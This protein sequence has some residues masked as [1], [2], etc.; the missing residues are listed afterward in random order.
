[1]R[2]FTAFATC[3]LILGSLAVAACVA[4]GDSNDP[5]ATDD[6]IVGSAASADSSGVSM[7]HPDKGESSP[8]LVGKWEFI[9]S[10]SSSGDPPPQVDT[11]FDFIN[12]T[13]EKLIL[14]YAFFERDGTFCGCDRDDFEPDKTVS[15]TM[16]GESRTDATHSQDHTKFPKL[17][18]C[19]DKQG[20]MKAI[21]FK[22]KGKKLDLD[23]ATQVGFQIRAFADV[24]EIGTDPEFEAVKGSVM[25][26]SGLK[27]V[28]IKQS[29]L[30]EIREIHKQ[31]IKVV[32][33][34]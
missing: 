23:D 9:P 3:S 19:H 7:S 15:Y 14:E 18:N 8:Y 2:T 22:R 1:M 32:G 11:E 34:L 20:A 6:E 13:H 30:E 17:F 28:A 33:P 26:E 24:Q 21:A 12:P 29:T 16:F 4:Q 5:Q 31:C 27:G 10:S 25:T